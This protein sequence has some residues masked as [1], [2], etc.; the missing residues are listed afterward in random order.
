MIISSADLHMPGYIGHGN[1][2]VDNNNT[3]REVAVKILRYATIEE[4][5]V[6]TEEMGFKFDELLPHG[7]YYYEVEVLD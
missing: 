6:Q 2:T 4:Y 7:P 3:K 5:K 1:M